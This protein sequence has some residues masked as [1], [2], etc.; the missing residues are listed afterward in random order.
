MLDP[1]PEDGDIID[2][3]AAPG[4]KTTHLGAILALHAPEIDDHV[5]TIHAFEKDKTRA[6]TFKKMVALA[7]CKDFTKIHAA[8]DFLR[9]DPN[10]PEYHKIGALLLD[11]SCSGSGIVGRDEMPTL[12]LPSPP[13]PAAN[14]TK[15]KPE[16]ETKETLKRKRTSPT[17]TLDLIDDNGTMTPIHSASDLQTRLTSL[18][19]FQLSLVLHAFVF[20]IGPQNDLFYLLHPHRRE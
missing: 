13:A 14:K 17:E 10:A 4:N 8:Q 6:E 16:P 11:P 5:Q 15:G 20:A 2:T 12:H 3:C 1:L 18:S 19:T 7:G 9:A